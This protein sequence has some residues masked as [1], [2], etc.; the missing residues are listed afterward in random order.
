MCR[1]F[2][3]RHPNF[4]KPIRKARHIPD[5]LAIRIL[6]C[7]KLVITLLPA[8]SFG[9]SNTVCFGSSGTASSHFVSTSDT[10][11]MELAAATKDPFLAGVD[12]KDSLGKQAAIEYWESV[13]QIM[14]QEKYHDP[15][16][17]FRFMEY[18]AAVRD[19]GRYALATEMY[20]WGLRADFEERFAEEIRLEML[21]LEPL[22][23]RHV[24]RQWDRYFENRDPRLFEE[25]NEFWIRQDFVP[26]SNRNERLLEH[27]QRIHYSR[28]NFTNDSSTIYGADAR[29]EIFVRLGPPDRMRSGTF[30]FNSGE[31][32]RRIYDLVEAGHIPAGQ[33]YALQM[34]IMQSYSPGS[35][36][37]W[38]YD[39]VSAEGPVIYLFGRPGRE[40]RY[41][42]MDSLDDFISNSNYRRLVHGRR[43]TRSAFR[44]G[45]FLQLMLYNEASTLDHYFGNRL[46][47][48]DRVWSEALFRLGTDARMIGELNSPQIAAYDMERMQ[49]RAPRTHSSY[50][51]N[52]FAYP[53]QFHQYRF[54]DKDGDPVAFLIVQPEEAFHHLVKALDQQISVEIDGYLLRQGFHVFANGQK[55][56]QHQ[57]EF[58]TNRND[59]GSAGRSFPSR[60]TITVPN[61]ETRIQLF[62]ELYVRPGAELAQVIRNGLIAAGT[63][64]KYAVKPIE[65]NGSLVISDLVPGRS[66]KPAMPLRM[67]EI[68][69]LN[70]GRIPVAE[71]LQVYFEIYNLKA[72]ETGEHRYRITYRLKPEERRWFF[73]RRTRDVT[74]SWEATSLKAQ[75]YQFFEV[76]LSHADT[77]K[78]TLGITVEDTASGEQY[79]RNLELYVTE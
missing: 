20:F 7:L 42:L 77:G 53:L 50:E 64:W 67:A 37:F 75:D 35:Y 62:S 13:Y 79:R 25:I 26:S 8:V 14:Q 24:F 74:L 21:M 51:Q 58:L 10:L 34:S 69:V 15:R 5:I 23:E 76:D 18:T 22:L 54:L 3:S 65:D 17:G 16:I 19:T 70:N 78:Y 2:R 11:E 55:L 52:F 68:G 63:E 48:Y 45:Y 56:A 61:E 47:E 41:R 57:E 28:R 29:A 9:F 44:A 49:N 73:R 1:F 36:D 39:Q 30:T 31:I 66:G 4:C 60:G 71:D 33:T 40:G 32:R 6:F 46:M 72:N 27:W 38:R 43:G 59:P 12:L